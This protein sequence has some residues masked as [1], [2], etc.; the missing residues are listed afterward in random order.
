M[1]KGVLIPFG[2]FIFIF[3]GGGVSATEQMTTASRTSCVA[4]CAVFFDAVDTTTIQVW[5]SGVVQPGDGDF[6]SFFYQWDFGDPN[7]GNWKYGRQNSDGSYPSKNKATGYVAGHVYEMPGDYTIKLNVTDTNG[8]VHEYTQN[9]TVSDF[10]LD[11]T[12]CFS[13]IG[14]FSE[15]PSGTPEQNKINTSSFSTITSYV[16]TGRRL[17]LRRGDS[18]IVDRQFTTL[19]NGPVMI[20]EFGSGDKPQLTASVGWG[21]SML[22]ITKNDW[23]F[24]NL[25]LVHNWDRVQNSA[26]AII[27]TQGS[28]HTLISGV[29]ATRWGATAYGLSAADYTF[30][31]ESSAT[32]GVL[33]G[34]YSEWTKHIAILGSYIH[35]TTGNGGNLPGSHNMYTISNFK[36]VF[37]HNL[38]ENPGNFRVSLRVSGTTTTGDTYLFGSDYVV[39]SDNNLN[40]GPTGMMGFD[41]SPNADTDQEIHHILIERNRVYGFGG[42]H[43]IHIGGPKT[44]HIAVFNNIIDSSRI[45]INKDTPL[46]GDGPKDIKIFNNLFS[47]ELSY[48]LIDFTDQFNNVEIRNNIFHSTQSAPIEGWWARGIKFP[49]SADVNRSVLSNNLYYHTIFSPGWNRTIKIGNDADIGYTLDKFKSA[50]PNQ[51]I[52]SME[53]D[54]KFISPSDFHLESTSSA[55]NNGTQIAGLFEDFDGN[56]RTDGMP[57]IGAY[58]YISESP[59]AQ[60]EIKKA[61]WRVV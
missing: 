17:L 1:K 33:T 39:I 4:P 5:T 20:G 28:L 48:P 47:S 61:Y 34:V 9:I 24:V 25:K 53:D 58:E 2:L 40:I 45:W 14:D 60:C 54:P 12:Y 11:N 36:G 55:I 43:A 6:A 57:D 30:L 35:D 26:N 37:S 22:R 59:S 21:D 44:S 19:V 38:L 8:V 52:G 13:T 50:Y 32:D 3:L 15:C 16:A 29:D 49:T 18:W 27:Q 7:S 51:E 31:Y 10:D 41:I 23:R 46:P 56:L 42:S